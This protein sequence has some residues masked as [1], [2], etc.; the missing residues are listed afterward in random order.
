MGG[1]YCRRELG[2]TQSEVAE[3]LGVGRS[4]LGKIEIRS[5][6]AWA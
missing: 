5:L 6:A 1:C 3:Q 2:L 4:L